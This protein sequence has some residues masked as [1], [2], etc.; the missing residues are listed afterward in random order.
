MCTMDT[1]PKGKL[2]V[3]HR[4][5]FRSKTVN[6]VIFVVFLAV[7][8]VVLHVIFAAVWHYLAGEADVSFAAFSGCLER[9]RLGRGAAG[10][11]G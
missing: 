11:D 3:K 1:L 10:R 4:S 7:S 9:P 5:I 2:G 6:M 8:G